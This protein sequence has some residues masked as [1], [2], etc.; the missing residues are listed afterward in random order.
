MKRYFISIDLN[1]AGIE[2]ESQEEALKEANRLIRD[3]DYTLNICDEEE[4]K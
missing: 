1:Q 2:A 3:G 4:I